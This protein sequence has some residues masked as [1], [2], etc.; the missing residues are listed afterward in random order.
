[1]GEPRID[2]GFWTLQHNRLPGPQGPRTTQANW[3]PVPRGTQKC[4]CARVCCPLS[5][6]HHRRGHIPWASPEGPPWDPGFP[7]P[8][9]L[10]VS[11]VSG[12]RDCFAPGA[13]AVPCAP[14]GTGAGCETSACRSPTGGGVTESR[15]HVNPCDRSGPPCCSDEAGGLNR[16]P[17]PFSESCDLVVWACC[18]CRYPPAVMWD[19]RGSCRAEPWSRGHG[20]PSPRRR[21]A[22]GTRDWVTVPAEAAPSECR[23]PVPAC[24]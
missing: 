11:L 16:P 21:D 7:P 13:S 5:E 23:L 17:R 6:S 24:T 22:T 19:P 1:M 8:S 2:Q 14:T 9:G 10:P 3:Y 4:T 18:G 15:C 20:E 12:G